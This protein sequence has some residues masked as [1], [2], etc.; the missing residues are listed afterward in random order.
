MP[1]LNR[2]A[3]TW[4]KNPSSTSTSAS[5]WL[6]NSTSLRMNTATSSTTAASNPTSVPRDRDTPRATARM[7]PALTIPLG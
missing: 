4:V 3:V 7:S 5:R 1:S 6:R 2:Y